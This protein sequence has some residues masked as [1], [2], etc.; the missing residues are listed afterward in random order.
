[1][2]ELAD[3]YDRGR[4]EL[5]NLAG[6]GLM[7]EIVAHELNRATAYTLH[8]L[9]SI[10]TESTPPELSSTLKTLGYQL[11]TISKR[12]RVL[13]P[14]STA[15]RQR[16][17]S[18]DMVT[19]VRD[20]IQSHEAQFDRH[21]IQ[22][23]LSTIPPNTTW[24][25]K[26]VKGMVVQVLDNLISNSVYWIKQQ[27]KLYPAAARAINIAL[28]VHLNRIVFSDTGPG[29]DPSIQYDIFNAFVT[30]KPP[31][32]GKGLGLFIAREI[33]KYHGAKLYLS[34]ER[35]VHQDRLNTFIFEFGATK[36]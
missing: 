36:E 15:G 34:D 27:A 1:M 35:T 11:E 20:T 8:L 10:D 7:V 25:V 16:K 19:L 21:K 26:L 4:T 18:F 3:S 13:D 6:V 32:E 9:S 31:G 29:V 5:V 33:A 14:V 17:V 24:Q 23:S 30:H 2:K 28:D 22:A 12:L